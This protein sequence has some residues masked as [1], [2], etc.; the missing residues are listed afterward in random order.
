MTKQSCSSPAATVRL[1]TAPF[2]VTDPSVATSVIITWHQIWCSQIN[3]SCLMFCPQ[4]WCWL[5][6]CFSFPQ[7]L[8]FY[9]ENKSDS[10]CLSSFPTK[11]CVWLSFQTKEVLFAALRLAFQ[12]KYKRLLHSM[13]IFRSVSDSTRVIALY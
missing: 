2:G 8:S 13:A 6:C 10:L 4:I 9:D 5:G 1:E 3:F 12:V 7:F 11:M